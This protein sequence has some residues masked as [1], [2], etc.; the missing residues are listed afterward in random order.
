LNIEIKPG[1]KAAFV[2]PSGAGK[3]TIAKL[4]FRLYDVASGTIKIDGVD[5]RQ[6]SKED[7]AKLLA[8][9]PQDPALFNDTIAAN[10]RFGKLDATDDE[11]IAAAKIAQIHDFILTLPKGYQTIVGERGIKVSGGERQRVAIARAIIK[12]PKILVFDEATSSLDSSNEKAVLETID[13][14]ASGRTS[15]SIAHRLSTIVNCDIIFVLKDGRVVEKGTH[16]E[17]LKSDSAYAKLWKLQTDSKT[18]S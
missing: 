4:I 13:R 3:S 17:L 1:Q 11:V 2:G 8:I 16:S 5:I 10:I 6:M 9:V 14:V 15:I 12:D 7:R 18:Q